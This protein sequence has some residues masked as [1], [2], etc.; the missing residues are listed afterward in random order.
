MYGVGIIT[1]K[2]DAAAAALGHSGIALAPSEWVNVSNPA[3]IAN[4]D[5]LSFYFNFQFRG[6]YAREKSG[7]ET[8]SIYSANIDGITMGFRGRKWLA[9]AFGYA[10]YSTVGYRMSEKKTIIGTDS[11]YRNE[12]SG[13]GGLSQAFINAAFVSLAIWNG[14]DSAIADAS[15][16]EL[17]R[18]IFASSAVSGKDEYCMEYIGFIRGE[19]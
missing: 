2:E 4:L 6:F 19:V 7:Y 10:P 14:L 15:N 3:G 11:Q 8:A 17:R 13:S 16:E 9:M 18:A 1:P 12:H 5:S